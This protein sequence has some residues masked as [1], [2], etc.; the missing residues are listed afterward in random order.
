[1]PDAGRADRASGAADPVEAAVRTALAP[2]V[3][4]RDAP[5]GERAPLRVAVALS[6]GRDS[7][8]LLDALAALAPEL[9]FAPSALHV[10]HGLS[11]NA[12]AWAAFCAAECER[13]GIALA[14]RRVDVPRAPGASV[15]AA[16]RSARFAALAEAD[17]DIVAL[18]HHADDQAETLL[19]QLLR[20]AGPHGLAAMSS[21][22]RTG[23][24]PLVRP[25]LAVSRASIEAYARQHAVAW[26]DDESNADTRFR[27]NRLRHDIA[28]RLAAAF[29]GFPATLVRAAAHQAEAAL[30]LDELAA[31]DAGVAGD[32]P[33]PTLDRAAL[34]ALALRSPARA[35]NLLRWFIRRH[36]LPSPSTARL[37]AMLDQL[38]RAAPDAKPRLLHAGV[39]LGIHRG[40]IAVHPPAAGRYA[41]R[42]DGERSLQL[43]H[44]T[45][46]F[47][48]VPGAGLAVAAVDAAAVVVRP[49]EGG[50]RIRLA[51]NRPRQPLKRLLQEAGIPVWQR[52]EWPLVWCGDVLAA[53]PGI[54][55]AADFR[56]PAG[57]DGYEL[58]W[59]RRGC[60]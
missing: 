9:A 24:P 55:V 21:L 42:W 4:T 14:V 37:A 43:P 48:C 10:H 17:A 38:V 34:A 20:G 8:V 2:I 40:R 31:Q 5:S 36:A 46:E 54:G 47:G 30:L 56:A 51:A 58:S 12:D 16:A 53:V 18:A 59:R 45:L 26:I 28:P 1:V 29:P 33:A 32:D 23:G 25:L 44:G 6:G 19:L 50:E 52:D 35:R 60:P 22:R 39:E 49:R 41:V 57:A 3:A 11:P 7:M 27:R 15:E 13:R